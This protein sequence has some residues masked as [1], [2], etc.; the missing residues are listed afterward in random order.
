[1][2]PILFGIATFLYHIATW[3]YIVAS[4]HFRTAERLYL[5]DID[6]RLRK[7]K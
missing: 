6:R 1:M 4:W 2:I 5:A 3:T 7:G